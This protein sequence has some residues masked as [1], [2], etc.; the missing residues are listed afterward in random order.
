MLLAEDLWSR[1]RPDL[2]KVR[3]NQ[4]VLVSNDSFPGKK[5]N[6]VVTYIAS[7]SEFTPRNVQSADERRNQVFAIKIR[8]I[9]SDGVFKSGMAAEVFIPLIQK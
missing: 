2:G 8:V 1:R 3:L 9:D 7:S 4:K 5:F 6:G